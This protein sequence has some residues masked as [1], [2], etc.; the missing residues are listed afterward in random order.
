ME[1][2]YWYWNGRWG[3]LAR[4]DIKV[5]RAG[6]RLRLEH[7]RGGVEGRLIAAYDDLDD[8]RARDLAADLAGD[9]AE[10]RD[11]SKL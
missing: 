9:L 2:V 7:W 6:E 5:F 3:R 10:W 11:L 8:P 1:R 4:L